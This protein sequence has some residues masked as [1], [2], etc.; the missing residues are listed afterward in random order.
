M[1]GETAGHY[2]EV[3][4]YVMF[5]KY[6]KRIA[7]FSG[8]VKYYLLVKILGIGLFSPPQGFIFLQSIINTFLHIRIIHIRM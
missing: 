6:A 7:F 3:G 1:D 8:I 5:Y 2:E 4:K